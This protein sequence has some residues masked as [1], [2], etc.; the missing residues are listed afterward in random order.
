MS[1][2]TNRCMV[3]GHPTVSRHL[4]HDNPELQNVQDR[5]TA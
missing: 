1:F 5:Q 3:P 2:S 4:C